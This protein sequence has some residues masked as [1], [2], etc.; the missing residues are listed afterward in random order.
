MIKKKPIYM[1]MGLLCVLFV[2][3]L[4]LGHDLHFHIYRI[5]AMAEELKRTGFAMPIRILSASYNE[6]GYG[7]PLFYGDVLLYIPALLVTLGMDAVTAYRLLVVAL[8]LFVFIAMYWQMYRVSRQKDFSFICAVFYAFSSYVLTDLCIRSAVGETSTFIFLPFV[9]GAFY[10]MVYQPRKYDWLYLAFGMSGLILS[11]NLTAFFTAAILLVWS[12]A[13]V[14]KLYQ[15]KSI[16]RIV[17]AAVATVG[18]VASYIFPMLEAMLVQE[19]RTPKNNGY[20][21]QEFPKHALDVID[22]FVPY[23]IKKGLAVVFDLNFDIETWHPGAVGLFLSL[24]FVLIYKTRHRKKKL[25]LQ[26]SFWLSVLLYAYMFIEPLVDWSGQYISFMQFEWRLLTFPAFI[27]S[28]YAAYLLQLNDKTIW[29]K[30]YVIL[31]IL[32]GLGTIGGRYAYQAYLDCRGMDYIKE[33]NE[34]YYESYI[35]E[36][37]PNNGDGLYL[38]KGVVLELYEERGEIIESNHTDVEF[39]FYRDNGKVIIDVKNNPYEDTTLELPLYYYKGYRALGMQEYSIAPS[40]NRLVALNIGNAEDSNII[41]WY[42]GTT[43]QKVSD[44]ISVGTILFMIVWITW[45]LMKGRRTQC[46]KETLY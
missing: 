7:V 42:A 33:I 41:V 38:P 44:W 46:G 1:V 36:Y 4:P 10:N 6:Y 23:E 30:S 3:I 14:K 5:G 15:N 16:S 21:M 34:E 12:I 11:H 13:E 29:K 43:V 2:V 26:I 8:F 27:F 17:I 35:M 37:S 31:A 25:V 24:I 20:Q 40:E 18:S 19:Y 39:S 28:V 45:Q 32:I 9:F 22:F